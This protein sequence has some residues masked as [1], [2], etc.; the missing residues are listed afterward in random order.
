MFGKVHHEPKNLGAP[1]NV[2]SH[3]HAHHGRYHRHYYNS[4]GWGLGAL[5]I[6]SMI[7]IPI[8]LI[9]LT[10]K[11]TVGAVHFVVTSMATSGLAGAGMGAGLRMSAVGV[12]AGA[13]AG[14]GSTLTFSTALGIGA[15]LVYGAIGMLYLYSSTKECYGSN[16]NVFH[17]IKSQVVNEDGLSF[18]GAVKSIGAIL[19][20]PFLLIGGLAGMGAKA[21]VQAYRSRF[22]HS[23]EDED[24]E[25]EEIKTSHTQMN[26]LGLKNTLNT[27]LG[28]NPVQKVSLF[29]DP[30][31][32]ELP[33]GFDHLPTNRSLRCN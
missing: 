12:G 9:A 13:G 6:S 19:W 3:H 21:A 10:L 28:Q 29:Y 2:H 14:V 18:T 11:L 8:I 22:S 16:R 20:S 23:K 30:S 17:M 33:D 7:L 1:I 32:E 15:F 26:D 25:F 27:G 5:L 24:I 31:T 4:S